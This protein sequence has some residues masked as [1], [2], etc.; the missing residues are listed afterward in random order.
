MKVGY[1]YE[2]KSQLF[3]PILLKMWKMLICGVWMAL[4]ALG[5]HKKVI[6]HPRFFIFLTLFAKLYKL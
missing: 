2:S 3:N 4:K 6:L 5:E 1:S